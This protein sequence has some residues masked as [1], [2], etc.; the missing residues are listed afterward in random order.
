MQIRLASLKEGENPVEETLE[1]GE[2]DLDETHFT[3]PI[4]ITGVIEN[5]PRTLDIR[6]HVRTTG[7]YVC[8]RCAI[9][10]ERPF[11][12]DVRVMVLKREAQD[13]DE[14]E[15][16][17][18][19]FLGKN[20][21]TL[22]LTDEILDALMLDVPIRVLCREECMGLCTLCGADLNEE[23]VVCLKREGDNRPCPHGATPA[24]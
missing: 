7:E 20:Q 11:D 13:S 15:T 4:D 1:P 3:R 17:G 18:M 12:V 19:L 9:D 24:G 22:D 14:E 5:E 21:D 8:D 10:F 6:L 16:E 23:P 2:L